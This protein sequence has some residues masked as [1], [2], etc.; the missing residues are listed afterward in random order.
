MHQAE[1][2]AAANLTLRI[3]TLETIRDQATDIYEEQRAVEELAKLK[4]KP[5]TVNNITAR[6]KELRTQIAELQAADQIK[7]EEK[8]AAAQ[9]KY[10]NSRS[11]K[12]KVTGIATFV[13]FTSPQ[14]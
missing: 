1:A 11:A 14:E 3:Q 5:A 4:K 6:V 7:Y 9:L 2:T 13:V 8:V 12:L 10:Q